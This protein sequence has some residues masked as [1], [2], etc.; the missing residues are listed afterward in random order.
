MFEH[1][2]MLDE[3]SV[4]EFG[5][6]SPWQQSVALKLRH[7]TRSMHEPAL[8]WSHMLI[9]NNLLCYDLHAPLYWVIV[10]VARVKAQ[11][12]CSTVTSMGITC[13]KHLAAMHYWQC[14]CSCVLRLHVTTS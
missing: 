14:C 4:V 8:L 13:S 3:A 10:S 2:A 7:V 11:T 12:I 1:V 9:P 6:T 5:M